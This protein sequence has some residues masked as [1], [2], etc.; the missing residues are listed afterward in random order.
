MCLYIMKDS[1]HSVF[2][3]KMKHCELSEMKGNS[4]TFFLYI[5]HTSVKFITQQ[6]EP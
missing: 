2:G 3:K 1:W 5:L 4:A 6:Q